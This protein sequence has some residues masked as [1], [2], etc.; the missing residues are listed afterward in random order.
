MTRATLARSSSLFVIGRGPSLA[1]AQEASLKLKETSGLHAEAFSAA[2]VMHGPLELVKEG[3]PVLI[4][5]PAD[6][7]EAATLSSVARLEA[8]GAK[9]ICIT[10][11]GAGSIALPYAPSPDPL[12]DPISMILSFYRMADDLSRQRGRNPDRPRLLNKETATL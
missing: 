7:A 8:A 1:I 6:K 9:T 12:L 5:C 10:R 3:F 2:E 11:S 4:F